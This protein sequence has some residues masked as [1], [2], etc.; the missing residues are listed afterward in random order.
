MSGLVGNPKDRFSR[1]AAHNIFY[2][3]ALQC[4]PNAEYKEV[5]ECPRSC[6]HD[7]DEA[8]TCPTIPQSGCACKAG[9]VRR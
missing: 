5:M 7:P 2:I 9:Y 8:V 3:L 6:S 4:G 1:G